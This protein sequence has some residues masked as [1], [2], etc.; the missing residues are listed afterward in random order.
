[1]Q[2]QSVQSDDGLLN[3]EDNNKNQV[4]IDPGTTIYLQANT[5]I[6]DDPI[7]VFADGS[8]KEVGQMIAG[9]NNLQWGIVGG[10]NENLF[11]IDADSGMLEFVDTPANSQPDLVEL[12]NP[13]YT[14]I[15]SAQGINGE[16]EQ[17]VNVEIA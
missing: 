8:T 6:S 15:V 1:M 5:T 3:N 17:R 14:V 9:Q 10:E 12:S 13:I 11:T 7:T 16:S 2:I 4:T